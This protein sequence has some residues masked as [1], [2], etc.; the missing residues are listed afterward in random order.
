[1]AAFSSDG[2]A[3]LHMFIL[4]QLVSTATNDALF[5]YILREFWWLS[6]SSIIVKYLKAQQKPGR[7]P[8]NR[9]K[10]IKKSPENR[11]REKE[12]RPQDETIKQ[13]RK[14]KIP[15]EKST[16]LFPLFIIRIKTKRN[17]LTENW[18]QFVIATHEDERTCRRDLVASCLV[19]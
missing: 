15:T 12:S 13:S 10:Q 16:F 7:E 5:V 4:L 11:A 9:Y 2:T 17:T 18:S 6:I 1:M 14:H 3:V 8:K 19:A